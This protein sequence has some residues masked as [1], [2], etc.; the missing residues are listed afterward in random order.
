MVIDFVKADWGEPSRSFPEGNPAMPLDQSNISQTKNGDLNITG[1]LTSNFL[2][3]NKLSFDDVSSQI[4]LFNGS[5]VE[6]CKQPKWSNFGDG[7]TSVWNKNGSG[8]AYFMNNVG[9]GNTNPDYDLD[10]NGNLNFTGNIY[11]NGTKFEGGGQDL[12]LKDILDFETLV[13]SKTDRRD[14]NKTFGCG[15]YSNTVD[16]NCPSGFKIISGGCEVN[17]GDYIKFSKPIENGWSCKGVRENTG[18]KDGVSV[19]TYAICG[20]LDINQV[21]VPNDPILT[22]SVSSCSADKPGAIVSITVSWSGAN[23]PSND[24]GVDYYLLTKLVKESENED[25][26]QSYS[27]KVDASTTSITESMATDSNY[28]IKVKYNLKACNSAGCSSAEVIRS[29]P[30]CGELVR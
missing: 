6:E 30:M 12:I 1:S 20:R 29:L 14:C 9:I 21:F 2:E 10:I 7:T 25:Y 18:L 24:R 27:R 5:N 11:Q 16:V 15:E 28:N 22:T 4:C 26:R 13:K 17:T 3:T 8:E 19:T 23:D